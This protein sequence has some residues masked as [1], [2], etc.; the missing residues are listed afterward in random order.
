MKSF[1][2]TQQLDL[3]TVLRDL[4]RI[5]YLYVLTAH[6]HLTNPFCFNGDILV[7]LPIVTVKNPLSNIKQ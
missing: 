7:K 4:C 1:S 6:N 5:T 2:L 3:I